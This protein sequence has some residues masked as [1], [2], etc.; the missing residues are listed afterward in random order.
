MTGDSVRFPA[1]P[2]DSLRFSVG[3]HG[4]MKP[5]VLSLALSRNWAEKGND[6]WPLCLWRQYLSNDAQHKVAAVVG[7]TGSGT[8]GGGDGKG[9]GR[10]RGGT[11][12]P[13][14]LPLSARFSNWKVGSSRVMA[15][16]NYVAADSSNSI[17]IDQNP[18]IIHLSNRSEILSDS[19]QTLTERKRFIVD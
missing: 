17:T 3:Q 8:G 9:N 16:I 10:A 19:E 2:C 11:Q 18:S 14:S 6:R 1:I 13:S 12:A 5:R 15:I 4:E 7:G